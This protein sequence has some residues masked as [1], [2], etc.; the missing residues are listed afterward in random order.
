MSKVDSNYERKPQ[1]AYQTPAW[2]LECVLPHLP[3]AR[4]VWEPACGEG[5]LVRVLT[6][7][8]SFPEIYATDIRDGEDFF[9]FRDAQGCD[10]IVSNPPYT[11]SAVFIQHA[12]DLMQ[13]VSGF[14][15]MLLPTD[16]S[17]AKGRRSL[18]AE[19]QTFAK[20]IELQKRIVWFDRQDG[21]RAQPSE[22]HAWY[23][24]HW[25]RTGRP[26]LAWAP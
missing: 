4:K 26:S 12:L 8:G 17:H 16:Y 5:N 20:K 13:P 9:S 7:S 25:G 19:S 24:W 18:F 1:D 2:C 22:W 23:L 6:D 10:A 3:W 14:V 21:K 15:F 11:D